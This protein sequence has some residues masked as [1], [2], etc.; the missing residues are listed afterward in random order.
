MPPPIAGFRRSVDG[1]ANGHEQLIRTCAI[2]AGQAR[3]F[4]EH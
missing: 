4:L 1:L 2:P 3:R